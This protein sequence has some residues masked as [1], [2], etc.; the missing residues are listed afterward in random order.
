MFNKKFF[1][2]VIL[3]LSILTG[4]FILFSY[5]YF[6]NYYSVDASPSN[7]LLKPALDNS[8]I[9]S[10]LTDPIPPL[11]ELYGDESIRIKSTEEFVDPGYLAMDNIDGDITNNVIV[12]SNIDFSTDGIYSITY[13]VT[14]SSNNTTSIS[15]NIEVYSIPSSKVVYLT[16]DDGPGPYTLELLDVL[17]KYQVKATFFVTNDD[18]DY[19]DLI[20]EIYR[21]GHTIGV[22]SATHR[23]KSIYASREAFWN[24]MDTMNQVIYDQTG[25][26]VNLFRFPGGSS[27]TV[28]SSSIMKSLIS[29]MNDKGYRY[30]DWNVSAG[31]AENSHTTNSIYNRVIKGMASHDVSIVLQHDI[32]QDSVAAVESIIKWGLENGY[33]FWPIDNDTEMVHHK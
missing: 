24:D 33:S 5:I 21:R 25:T 11:I 20:G 13:T 27:N 19:I 8:K 16:F 15:R 18:L 32:K 31:D 23:Y 6:I 4:L 12:D 17:D 7:M 3:S 28:C 10:E 30:C 2:I 22:H 26:Y 29:D 9:I 1:T 14:D